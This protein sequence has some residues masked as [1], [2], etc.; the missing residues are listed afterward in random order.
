[1][2]ISKS[3]HFIGLITAVRTLASAIASVM[4][5]AQYRIIPVYSLYSKT[6]GQGPYLSCILILLSMNIYFKDAL[7][8]RPVGL[9]EGFI[10]SI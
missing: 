9:Q 5:N 4:L 8:L 7:V 10:T 2:N 6:L 1:M 3:L